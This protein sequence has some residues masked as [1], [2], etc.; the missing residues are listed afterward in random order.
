MKQLGRLLSSLN[1]LAIW[2]GTIV[3]FLLIV[4][5]TADV[6][7]RYLFNS[8]LPG[9]ILIVSV[10]YMIP[11][12]FLPLAAV[13]EDDGHITVELIYDLLAERIRWILRLFSLLLSMTVFG[14]LALRTFE[15][16]ILKFDT[17]TFAMEAGMRIP[18]WPA[19]FTLP[20]GFGLMLLVLSYK[21]I[22]EVTGKTP[23]LGVSRD[24]ISGE[25]EVAETLRRG[26]E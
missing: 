9:T 24:G 1:G 13:E 12:V 17:G 23:A 10:F 2:F 20:I 18:T 14:A 5:V 25:A 3:V 19:Y 11:I 15:E 26:G 8:P 16:A 22:C 7:L 6:G 21:L 4:H